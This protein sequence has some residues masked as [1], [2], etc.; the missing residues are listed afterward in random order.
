MEAGEGPGYW[1]SESREARS[2]AEAEAEP[3]AS[4]MIGEEALNEGARWI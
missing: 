2:E 3:V 4:V 1:K